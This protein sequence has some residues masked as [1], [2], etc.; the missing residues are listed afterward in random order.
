MVRTIAKYIYWASTL[1][2][3]KKVR[4]QRSIARIRESQ[5][6]DEEYYLFWNP[7]LADGNIDALTHY[8]F[9]GAEECRDPHPLFSTHF[10]REQNPDLD[11]TSINPL[12]HF[13][14]TGHAEGRLP[15]PLLEDRTFPVPSGSGG[16]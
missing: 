16:G 12:E 6:F 14:R 4:L 13:V 7:E 3:V 15:H 9:H 5:I 8:V 2:L 11:L 1:Q 10:Y